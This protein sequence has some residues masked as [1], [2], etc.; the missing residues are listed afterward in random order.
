M[1]SSYLE[2]AEAGS[3]TFSETLPAFQSRLR[4]W[5]IARSAS[6]IA[7]PRSLIDWNPQT[8]HET[9]IFNRSTE[10]RWRRATVVF[11][12]MA[13]PSEERICQKCSGKNAHLTVRPP[14]L[15]GTD[16]LF[17]AVSLPAACDS[18]QRQSSRACDFG[19]WLTLDRRFRGKPDQG[20]SRPRVDRAASEPH[21]CT[22]RWP[23]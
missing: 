19:P 15:R 3:R 1:G 22:L 21:A 23:G 4:L 13:R 2:R 7:R 18:A 11:R 14:F 6:S 16:P 20:C 10:I 8:P 12:A 17:T 5:Y 9:R